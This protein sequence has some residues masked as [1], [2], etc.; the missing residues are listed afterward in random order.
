[1]H[2][3]QVREEVHP[4]GIST[5]QAGDESCDDAQ[6]PVSIHIFIFMSMYFRTSDNVVKKITLV[7]W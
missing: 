5:L 6:I 1:M 3:E 7:S 4:I 2:V